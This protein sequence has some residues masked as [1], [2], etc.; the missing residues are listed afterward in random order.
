MAGRRGSVPSRTPLPP[1][2]GAACFDPG[3]RHLAGG[4][5]G[6]GGRSSSGRIDHLTLG[7]VGPGLRSSSVAVY[8]RDVADFLRWW[9]RPPKE[10][11]RADIARYLAEQATSPASADRRLAILAYFYRAGI[12]A[13][14]WTS[15]PTVGIARA[16]RGSW[17]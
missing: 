10:A 11:T 2:P 5:G 12:A 15:D 13:R 1:T 9:G 17:R 14:L 8:R 4:P 7:L 6:D 16:R 3:N